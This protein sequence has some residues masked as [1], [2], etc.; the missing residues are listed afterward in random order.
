MAQTYSIL[1]DSPV[2]ATKDCLNFGKFVTP[3][4]ERLI[5]SVDNTPFTVGILADWGQGKSTVMRML[6][7]S[8]E[9]QG[10]ATAWFEP[11]KYTGREAVWKGLALTLVREINAND[12]L[13]KEL[14]RK[15]DGLKTF[16]AKALW[17]RLI[18]RE[19]AQDLVDTVKS[20]PWSPS[21]LHDFE[22]NFEVLFE[23][24]DPARQGTEKKPFVLF[25]DDLDRCLPESAL[26][27]LEAV[28][29][30]WRRAPVPS[31]AAIGSPLRTRA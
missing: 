21:L 2:D 19:W 17:S 30:R 15:K 23:H 11:W 10:C 13:R 1:G 29:G 18:G 20:E 6:K 14:G 8:L 3:F 7:A 26:A 25:V 12:S 5:Q 27:V 31:T 22:Q 4:A 9:G 24:I 28:D 16:A